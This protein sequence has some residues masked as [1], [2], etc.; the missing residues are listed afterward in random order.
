MFTLMICGLSVFAVDNRYMQTIWCLIIKILEVYGT[1]GPDFWLAA[2]FGRSSCVTH[3]D[4]QH[5]GHLA[6]LNVGH[7]VYHHVG[8][9]VS[10]LDGH[11]VCHLVGHLVG[12]LVGNLVNHLLCH[13]TL[14][15]VGHVSKP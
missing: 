4:D 1:P 10:H 7:R 9:H 2:L 13:L 11:L 6:H 14:H 3:L 5:V 12:N 8:H 15:L